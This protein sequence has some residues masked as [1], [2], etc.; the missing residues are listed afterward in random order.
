MRFRKLRIV[1]SAGCG[2]TCVLLIA[3]W[4]RSYWRQDNIDYQSYHLIE[5]VSFRG[6]VAL[7]E[8]EIAPGYN[9]PGWSHDNYPPSAQKDYW[10]KLL[11]FCYAETPS[12][13]QI[14]I[15]YWFITLLSIVVGTVPWL[16]WRFTLRTV[17]L[18][19][20]VVG[21]VLGLIV[22]AVRS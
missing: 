3:L 8:F 21:V 1:W 15:P 2:I 14:L 22:W 5:L 11:G 16:R 6:G 4:V 17:L 7:G 18:A 20:T 19:I 12:Y 9:S 13:S 10:P